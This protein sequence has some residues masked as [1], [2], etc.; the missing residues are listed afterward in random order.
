[1]ISNI[2]SFEIRI[3]KTVKCTQYTDKKKGFS[4]GFI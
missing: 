2:A 3:F 4:Y 1:M